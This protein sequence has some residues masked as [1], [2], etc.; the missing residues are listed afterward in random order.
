[1]STSP[2][3]EWC[4]QQDFSRHGL[5]EIP[6]INRQDIDLEH[7]Q[8]IRLEPFLVGYQEMLSHL[9]PSTVICYG[10]PFHEMLADNLVVVP[11]SRTSRVSTRN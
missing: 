5:F 3:L 1:M 4:F 6:Y 8:L 9:H 11:Y 2:T 7:L 10:E